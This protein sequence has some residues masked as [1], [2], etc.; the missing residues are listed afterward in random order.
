[1]HWRK[2][3]KKCYLSSWKTTRVELGYFMKL[4][5]SVAALMAA[6][7]AFSYGA[8]ARAQGVI[9][10]APV[11]NVTVGIDLIQ[12]Q[13]LIVNPGVDISNSG[14]AT[15]NTVRLS[16]TGAGVDGLRTITV[17][18]SIT[19]VGGNGIN[20]ISG[21]GG[22]DDASQSNVTVNV[23]QG[24]SIASTN[25]NGGSIVLNDNVTVTNSGTISA[26]GRA[27]DA[28]NNLVVNNATSS[29][30]ITSTGRSAIFAADTDSLTVNVSNAGTISTG[31]TPSAIFVNASGEY[32]TS[33]VTITNTGGTISAGGGAILIRGAY[34]NLSLTGGN[35]PI[36][37]GG[38][39]IG[40]GTTGF[41]GSVRQNNAAS[42]YDGVEVSA[43]YD[44]AATI[45]VGS[46]GMLTAAGTGNVVDVN[47]GTSAS[48]SL[49]NEG[50]I[51]GYNET[52]GAAIAVSSDMQATVS[53]HN[54]GSGSI[55]AYGMVVGAVVYGASTTVDLSVSNYGEISS[56]T[57]SGFD[58]TAR[59]VN[60]D[61]NNGES[62]TIST[63]GDLFAAR[64]M[65]ESGPVTINVT[66]FNNDGYLSSSSGSILNLTED[67]GGAAAQSVSA[68]ITNGT[69]GDMRSADTVVDVYASLVNLSVNNSGTLISNGGGVVHV[70]ADDIGEIGIVN[71][72]EMSSPNAEAIDIYGSGSESAPNITVG[73]TGSIYSYNGSATIRVELDGTVAGAVGITN[74]GSGIIE[75]GEYGT[76]I[77]ITAANASMI[78]VAN[79]DTA[80]IRGGEYG[81]ILDAGRADM[82]SVSNS[83]AGQIV[84]SD[85]GVLFAQN[86]YGGETDIEIIS[87]TNAGSGLIS[88]SRSGVQINAYVSDSITVQNSGS[89]TIRAG[90]GYRI[91]KTVSTTVGYAGRISGYAAVDISV[92]NYANTIT[93]ANEGSAQ[94]TSEYG[95]GVSIAARNAGGV[96]V[97]NDAD[98]LIS[99]V[100]RAV[101]VQIENYAETLTITNSGTISEGATGEQ[102]MRFD[103]YSGAV[104]AYSRYVNSVTVENSGE[105]TSTSGRGIMVNANAGR[106]FIGIPEESVE[107]GEISGPRVQPTVSVDNSGTITALETGIEVVAGD[108]SNVDVANSGDITSEYGSGIIVARTAQL[109]WMGLPENSVPNG[110]G[111]EI[112]M[113]VPP[114]RMVTISN[115]GSID[116]AEVG[117]G[118]LP[119]S[120]LGRVF[121]FNFSEYSTAVDVQNSGDIAAAIGVGIL[122]TNVGAVSVMNTGTIVATRDEGEGEL[123]QLT[124]IGIGIDLYGSY[125][126][127]SVSNTGSVAGDGNYGVAVFAKVASVDHTITID[128]TGDVVASNGIA[129]SVDVYGGRK[130][131][132]TMVEFGPS[133]EY[134][135]YVT[136][137]SVTINNTGTLSGLYGGIEVNIAAAI[138]NSGDITA[139]AEEGTA[140]AFGGGSVDNSGLIEGGTYGI[141][142]IAKQRL[143]FR[144]IAPAISE[145]Y[146]ATAA[147]SVQNTG[148][149][150]GG[151]IGI[152]ALGEFDDSVVND[153]GTI[154][155]GT[156]A[157][158]LGLGDD[159][160]VAMG[161]AVFTGN[162]DGGGGN[163]DLALD[164]FT[165][166]SFTP[167]GFETVTA[168]NNT[169]LVLD[170]VTTFGG[171]TLAIDGTS[172]IDGSR[173]N[174]G[175][176]FTSV[177][178]AGRLSLQDAA[179]GDRLRVTGTLA[180][181]GTI[182]VDV[183]PRAGTSD[184]VVVD[185]TANVR[186]ALDVDLV[187][188]TVGESEHIVLSAA[189]G[190]TDAGLVLNTQDSIV[191]SFALRNDAND[192]V[193]VISTDFAPEGLQ[194]DGSV[195]GAYLNDNADDP[196]LQ[197]IFDLAGQAGSVEELTALFSSLN[198]IDLSQFVTSANIGGGTFGSGLFSCA[199]GEGAFAA[200]DEGQCGWTRI[201]GSYFDRDATA[202]N[203]GVEETAFSVS[204]GGQFIYD[205]HIRLGAGVGIDIIDTDGSFGLS[206]DATRV[207]AGVSAKYVDGPMMAG[208]SVSG[209]VSFNDSD[210]TTALGTASASFETFDFSVIARAA[211]LADLG[212]GVYVKPQIQG[213][214]TYVDRGGFT[215]TGAGAANLAVS[216]EGQ[217]FFSVSPSIEIGTDIVMDEMTVRPYVR[218]GATI[219]SEDNVQTTARLAGAAS[220]QTFTTVTSTDN[221][222]GD[223]AVGATIFTEGDLSIR[224][225]YNGRFAD[226][227]MEHGGFLKLQMKF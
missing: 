154:S 25:G 211:Y 193:L 142:T 103:P 104:V 45:H 203:P 175:L 111:E 92:D 42:A 22:I 227:S 197:A 153:G 79:S 180:S 37:K 167:V 173:A 59:S 196:A 105:I 101:S 23:N 1:M 115:S 145:E 171:G 119:T 118:V 150:A 179:A 68:T 73:N 192:I 199:V 164:G 155:G 215:E 33:S 124:G 56:E 9:T 117:I 41:S 158:S 219:L 170:N 32:A 146:S 217:T 40:M 67:N 172:T 81:V 97:S 147:L 54:A 69:T 72:G 120:E 70:S 205:E 159:S 149:I 71:S 186:G 163:D 123:T 5:V 116:A 198:G 16:G 80:Q 52:A 209:G 161:A 201:T 148:T 218:V 210:R 13:D 178:N 191:S 136:P 140:I 107:I 141:A 130:Q 27:I 28:N 100:G 88:G 63:R 220:A 75:I 60:F 183:D 139:S 156:A 190:A 133:I 122:E 143:V 135:E 204:A 151:E 58:A 34:S 76:A 109:R 39:A 160:V 87:V 189:G 10:V 102:V 157:L 46:G 35:A 31:A 93:V 83:G 62:G 212:N 181:T 134:A 125:G 38:G 132:F 222:F 194:P 24:G 18:G 17:I 7:G 187:S 108:L 8:V 15:S 129:L 12:D 208:V 168:T 78:S 169:N 21:T 61:F 96:M 47:G 20:G 131:S 86:Q 182:A 89:A 77:S 206:A 49:T 113:E 224:A 152:L 2:K 90:G 176:T 65:S 19:N 213:G 3:L 4:N 55:S 137:S 53:L 85:V 128:N 226:D 84:G 14:A 202:T 94:I 185:G 121:G 26:V 207:H 166:P 6:A 144:A 223:V 177:S 162:V 95:T 66:S 11:A 74:S 50:R 114:V 48:L 221:V 36:M 30:S 174:N 138:T 126:P 98:A 44:A 214:V 43:I 99:G 82:L 29:A 225:E 165:G 184:R 188:T 57:N 110:L 112:E 51:Q 200:I 216:S 91:P 106:G 64:S 195:F 127:V